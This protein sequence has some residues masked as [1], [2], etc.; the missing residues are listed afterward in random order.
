M[1]FYTRVERR[2]DAENSGYVSLK[3]NNA[4]TIL[5]ALPRVWPIERVRASLYTDD[6]F[7]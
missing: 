5:G 4:R 3:S 2:A 7:K 1:K 6:I